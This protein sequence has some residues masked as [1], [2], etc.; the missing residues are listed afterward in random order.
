MNTSVEVFMLKISYRI[1][2]V[3]PKLFIK[4]SKA[5]PSSGFGSCDKILECFHV[6]KNDAVYSKYPVVWILRVRRTGGII[7]KVESCK[8]AMTVVAAE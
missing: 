2:N 1:L 3:I 5:I 8:W 7:L 6:M 4:Y